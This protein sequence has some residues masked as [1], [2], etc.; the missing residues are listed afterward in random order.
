MVTVAKIV[1]MKARLDGSLKV[2]T[3]DIPTGTARSGSVVAGR[4]DGRCKTRGLAQLAFAKPDAFSYGGWDY[5]SC[6][7]LDA[8]RSVVGGPPDE[9][10]V[11][12]EMCTAAPTSFPNPPPPRTAQLR[13]RLPPGDAPLAI[14]PDPSSASSCPASGVVAAPAA[15]RPPPPPKAFGARRQFR[16]ESPLRLR[17]GLHRAC[18]SQGPP[19]S[20]TQCPTARDPVRS[21]G[22]HAGRHAPYSP[23]PPDSTRPPSLSFFPSPTPPHPLSAAETKANRKTTNP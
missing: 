19:R 3:A 1:Q 4:G 6:R 22:K 17:K 23:F 15:A 10:V 5:Q 12:F 18:G 11:K 9:L 20:G 7:A 14:A 21:S 8:Q 2:T 13:T 16:T